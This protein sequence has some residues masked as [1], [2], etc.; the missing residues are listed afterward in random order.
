MFTLM[1]LQYVR[2]TLKHFVLSRLA[3]LKSL[4]VNSCMECKLGDPLY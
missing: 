2:S 4:R 3:R 1:A